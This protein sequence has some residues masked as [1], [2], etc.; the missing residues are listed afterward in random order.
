[1]IVLDTHAFFWLAAEPERLSKRAREAI[2]SAGDG[3]LALS[4]I[5]LFELAMMARSGKVLVSGSIDEW[6]GS[7]LEGTGTRVE[8]ISPSAAALAVRLPSEFPKDPA[9]RLIAGTALSRGAPLVTK[10]AKI[11]AYPLL[12]TIW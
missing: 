5:S 10:D 7:A 4:D 2:E 6:I 8:P 12:E 9:D 3:Q 1:M 11:R